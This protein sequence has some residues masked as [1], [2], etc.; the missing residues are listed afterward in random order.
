[1][2][3]IRTVFIYS[4]LSSDYD[5]SFHDRISVAYS[6]AHKVIPDIRELTVA[7]WLRTTDSN[8]GVPISYAVKDGAIVQDNA[9]ALQDCGALNVIINNKT[10]YTGISI[11][12]G[13]WHHVAI[14][15]QSG[16]GIWSAFL[17]GS[18]VRTSST[19][20]QQSQV[21]RGGGVLMSGQEQD[22]IGGGFNAEESY[23]GD[24][25]QMNIW[26]RV[27]SNNEVYNLAQS[28]DHARGDV[29]AWADFREDLSGVYTIT[30]KSYA[31][32]CK[33]ILRYCI[34]MMTVMMTIMVICWWR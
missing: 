16:S 3:L 14:T 6:K 32:Q 2:V 28:C 11:S 17:D 7:L 25:S 19:P 20:F 33:Y 34:T 29:V 27:L 10:A 8:P 18:R 5:L 24:I 4:G 13:N 31:C 12:D 1:M 21:I 22:E 30:P 26:K 9:L 23:I 15:W